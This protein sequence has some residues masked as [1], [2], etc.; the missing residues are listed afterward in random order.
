MKKIILIFLFITS[1]ADAQYKI[2]LIGDYGKNGSVNTL[3]VSQLVKSWNPKRIVTLGDNS[4]SSNYLDDRDIGQ[5]YSQFIRVYKGSYRWNGYLSGSQDS[6]RF[7]P[8]LGNHDGY[9]Y[10]LN[11]WYDYFGSAIDLV[12]S[13][14]NRRYYNVKIGGMIEFFICN[15]AYGSAHKLYG[16]FDFEPDGID[17][18]SIQA[19]WL[20][21]AMKNS[22]AK[23]KVVV[24]HHP[25]W[26]SVQPG[27]EDS[28]D[29][30][31]WNYK[32]WGADVIMCG[33]NH[34]YERLVIQSGNNAGLIVLVNGLGGEDKN[35][36]I[37][38]SYPGSQIQYLAEYG[39][40]LMT[41]YPDSL[42]IRMITVTNY[43][44][45][46]V[47]I[48]KGIGPPP[49][50]PIVDSLKNLSDS[51]KVLWKKEFN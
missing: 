6:S 50:P 36:N 25:P 8:T 28:Y 30:L 3:A 29:I 12:K 51:V 17:S 31:R 43:L 47:T 33:H 2:A 16:N 21:S 38:P 19:Q 24:M 15:S 11:Y 1:I 18:N 13:S 41:V 35:P 4:Y 10:T 45:D 44:V 37:M 40:Q 27:Y 20:K 48:K 49:P 14:G 7:I 32:L 34:V 23:W 9:A 26:S 39:A 22:T 5:F 42:N 46:N